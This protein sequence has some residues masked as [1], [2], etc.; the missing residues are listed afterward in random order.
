V[1]NQSERQPRDDRSGKLEG[2]LPANGESADQINQYID[3]SAESADRARFVLLVLVTTSVLAYVAMWNSRPGAWTQARVNV[4]TDAQLFYGEDKRLLPDNPAM[5]EEKVWP[6]F[7]S[8]ENYDKLTTAEEKQAYC[9]KNETCKKRRRA[10]NNAQGFISGNNRYRFADLEHLKGY[11]QSLERMRTER[12]L[13]LTVPFFGIVFDVNDLGMFAGLTFIIVLLLF[14]F[15]LLRELRNVRLVFKQAQTVDELELCYNRLA[16]QQVLT[17]PTP[18]DYEPPAQK[19]R[20]LLEKARGIFWE[21]V[22]KILYLLPFLTHLNIY[23]NDR[24]T[25][26]DVEMAFPG[27]GVSLMLSGLFLIVNV[28]LTGLCLYLGWK[29][30][31]TWRKH[32]QYILKHRPSGPD[33]LSGGGAEARPP[34]LAPAPESKLDSGIVKTEI[35]PKGTNRG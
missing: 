27:T 22:P 31:R 34:E 33:R 21:Y 20:R 30:D 16:M 5:F 3:A 6:R 7:Y 4:A 12:V 28:L 17:T 19:F 18:I 8:D 25:L 2:C 29:V 26:K 9:E 14:R 23:I 1:E 35:S 13:N 10:F 15:S 11:V 32:A 24:N